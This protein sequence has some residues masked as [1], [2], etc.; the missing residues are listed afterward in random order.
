MLIA[1]VVHA[2]TNRPIAPMS[3]VAPP[4]VVPS[5]PADSDTDDRALKRRLAADRADRA[6][7]AVAAASTP[8]APPP[9]SATTPAAPKKKARATAPAPR[10]T[11]AAAPPRRRVTQSTTQAATVTAPPA[12]GSRSSVVVGY[13]MAQVGKR[14][15]FGA[16]GPN[17]FDCSGLV[18]AAYG[19]VGIWTPHY[20]GDLLSRGR[21]VSQG[22]LQPGDL[23]FP[24]AGHVGIYIGGG[25]MVHASTVRT[26]VKVSGFYVWRARRL[27]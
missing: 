11:K 10:R 5:T 2:P 3:V 6:S 17:T 14:Y 4:P 21:A 20:T 19:K 24:H 16:A 8:P 7:R 27:L 22:E 26:G 15:V 1:S 13:A 18:Q 25:Q 9:A 12:D 23:I